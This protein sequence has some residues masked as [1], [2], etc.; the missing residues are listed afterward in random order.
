[1][2]IALVGILIGGSLSLL[3]LLAVSSQ[4]RQH[5]I[6]ASSWSARILQIGASVLIGSVVLGLFTDLDPVVY[7]LPLI[8]GAAM[9][10]AGITILLHER[11]QS[12]YV[13][14]RSL[15]LQVLIAGA[16]ELLLALIGRW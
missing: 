8:I 15:S 10:I 6:R 16:I 7:Q 9:V 3:G 13:F 12:G 11:Q 1:M 4:V 5:T 2:I 14:G